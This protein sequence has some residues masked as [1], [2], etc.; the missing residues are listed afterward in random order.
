MMSPDPTTHHSDAA[1]PLEGI[2][3]LDLTMNISGPYGT[4]IL[5]DLGAEVVKVERP[6]GGD[7][8]R[9]MTPTRGSGSAYYFAINRNKHS[10]VL[11][12]REPADRE[13]LEALIANSDVV[14]TNWRPQKL[15]AL[16]LDYGN[17]R[18]RHPH[19]V[20]ADISAYG[21][22]GSES[23]R[24]GYDMVLQAR[25]GLMSVNGEP[26]RP[27]VR[28]GVSILDMGSG[29]WLALGVLAA[30]RSRDA[31]GEGMQV[32]TSLL[33]VGAAFMAY[34]AAAFQLTGEAPPRRGS[35]HPAFGPYGVFTCAQG[36]QLAL[37]VGADHIFAR[38]AE[39]VGAPEW[40][41]DPRFATNAGRI[42]HEDAMRKALEAKLAGHTAGEW[43][44]RLAA[45][46]VPADQVAGVSD[47]LADSQLDA[48]EM[49]VETSLPPDADGQAGA[50]LRSPGIPVRFSGHRPSARRH[51]PALGADTS[52]ITG[53]VADA[54]AAAA[55]R[56]SE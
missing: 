45:H 13:L 5:G 36:T 46:D 11:D 24:A 47:V 8:S 14:A 23:E 50:A 10:V 22:I 16:G 28:V 35:G 48:V 38:L 3:V 51:P 19:V 52:S 25:S 37:G 42:E 17:V 43:A 9:R 32:S 7:D 18:A 56:G 29:I 6:G 15:A 41:S 21:N 39:G 55:R 31:T 2:R 54:Q 53:H 4:M 27:A 26:G 33:E 30:L 49:W 40:I 34:D 12:A 20:Y 1:L 44:R